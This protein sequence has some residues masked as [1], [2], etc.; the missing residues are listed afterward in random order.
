MEATLWSPSQWPGRRLLVFNT[1]LDPW[2]DA[3]KQQQ[4]RE[5]AGFIRDTVSELSEPL[6]QRRLSAHTEEAAVSV[7]YGL[8]Q[9]DSRPVS[10]VGCSPD[11][12]EWQAPNSDSHCSEEGL[13]TFWSNTA[14]LLVGDLNIKSSDITMY[15][16]ILEALGPQLPASDMYHAVEG[17]PGQLPAGSCSDTHTYDSTCNSLVEFP[18]DSGRIDHVFL[19]RSVQTHLPRHGGDAGTGPEAGGN[20]AQQLLALDFM[21]L[22]CLRFEVVKG[23]LGDELSDHWP[24]LLEIVPMQ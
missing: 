4:L 18:Q 9:A 6:M 24:L 3:N 19:L 21:P 10:D 15:G 20:S 16:Y 12:A 22:K 13:R 11:A 2:V 7:G 23:Q 14:V 1:H 5:I 8:P 17:R